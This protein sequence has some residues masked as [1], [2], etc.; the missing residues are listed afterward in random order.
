M[1]VTTIHFASARPDAKCNHHPP[2]FLRATCPSCH[3]TNSIK[4]LKPIHTK[5][6]YVQKITRLST[7]QSTAHSN[8]TT[9]PI[10]HT[11]SSISSRRHL[12]LASD[13]AAS[14]SRSTR[15]CSCSS[16]ADS[17]CNVFSNNKQHGNKKLRRRC[18]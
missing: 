5:T 8:A 3:P 18:T 12:S 17:S 15:C 10:E 16:S 13:S 11:F 1:A 6:A 2:Y 9:T 14:F 4:A 7:D